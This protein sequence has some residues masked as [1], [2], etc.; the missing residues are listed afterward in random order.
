MKSSTSLVAPLALVFVTTALGCGSA[1]PEV[2]APQAATADTGTPLPTPAPLP[3]APTPVASS[4]APAPAP[5]PAPP[6][7]KS[8]ATIGGT[9][10]TDVTGGAMVAELNKVGWVDKAVVVSGGALGA[11]ESVRFDLKK[12]KEKGYCEIV[13]PVPGAP[14]DKGSGMVPPK[15]Q[16][17]DRDKE[18]ATYLDEVSDVLVVVVVEGNPKQAKKLI[19]G[20]VK[21][22]PRPDD[23]SKGKAPKK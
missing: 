16:R 15:D 18:G 23:P 7:P 8:A 22:P 17:A 12:G 2:E 6:K 3:P 4:P 21:A 5:P 20:L 14:A 19:D 10:I 1:T 13:R 9:S 11:Y